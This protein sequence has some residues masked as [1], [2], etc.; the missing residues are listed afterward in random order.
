VARSYKPGFR[1]ADEKAAPSLR[2][3]MLAQATRQSNDK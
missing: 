2:E 1:P 3:L